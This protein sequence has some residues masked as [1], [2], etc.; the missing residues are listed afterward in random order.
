VSDDDLVNVY[1]TAEDYR[2]Y[3]PDDVRR[4]RALALFY[5]KYKP[6]IGQS[7]L[8][9]ACGGGVLGLVLDSPG[10]T[11]VG[12]D[13]NP[14]M[15]RAARTSAKARGSGQ[16]F[17]LGDVCRARIRGRFDTVTLLGNSLAH[18]NLSEMDELLGLRTANVG[19]GTTFLID[20]RDLVAMFWRGTWSRVKVQ[21][22]V[23]GKV[24][25]R[26]RAVD[27][28]AGRLRMRARPSSRGWVLDWTHAIWSPF[29]LESVMRSH[30]WRLVSRSPVGEPGPRAIPEHYIDVYRLERIRVSSP[31]SSRPGEREGARSL[32]RDK[33]PPT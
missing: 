13:A 29:I 9:L 31:H 10:R 6:F 28:V 25:H 32:P 26:A 7:V 20:Y 33:E 5:R 19:P 22:H 15:I 23:R 1:R 16:K 3:T 14:D 21:T 24:V 30:G 8:D 12:V 27:L 18:I 11:Y 4:R 17:V 2:R